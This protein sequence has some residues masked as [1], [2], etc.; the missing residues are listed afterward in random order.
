MIQVKQLDAVLEKVGVQLALRKEAE[1][2]MKQTIAKLVELQN[3]EQ[4]FRNTVALIKKKGT[5]TEEWYEK[6]WRP[7]ERR[8]KQQDLAPMI[9]EVKAVGG[10]GRIVCKYEGDCRVVSQRLHN[11]IREENLKNLASAFVGK[12][13]VRRAEEEQMDCVFKAIVQTLGLQSTEAKKRPHSRRCGQTKM[14]ALHTFS[15]TRVE[16]EW[17]KSS[18]LA[19]LTLLI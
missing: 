1:E 14:G 15:P 19:T 2:S 13:D 4:A 6:V 5:S 9:V 8:T 3:R 11:F 7:L 17:R 18:P 10:A 12:P 16:T